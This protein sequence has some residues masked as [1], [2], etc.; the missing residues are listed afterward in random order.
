MDNGSNNSSNHIPMS[1]ST[2]SA[3]LQR[4]RSSDAAHML[5]D[6]G[7]LVI[8]DVVVVEG[9]GRAVKGGEATISVV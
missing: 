6:L 3:W 7:R 9:R 5:L 2:T 4:A 8:V 1:S